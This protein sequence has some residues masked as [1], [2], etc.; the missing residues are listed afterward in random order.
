[1]AHE[2][3]RPAPPYTPDRLVL[4]QPV[5]LGDQISGWFFAAPV[6][7]SVLIAHDVALTWVYLL[8]PVPLWLLA[9]L[10][11]LLHFERRTMIVDR[12]AGEIVVRERV[13]K[14][15]FIERTAHTIAFAEVHGVSTSRELRETKLRLVLRG[16]PGVDLW[17]GAERGTHVAA[18]RLAAYLGVP[19]M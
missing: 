4:R 18:D 7:R 10:G 19:R 11:G 16:K 6:S 9:G 12:E 3:D 8:I 5:T 14:G 2:P 1:M 13:L 17:K 15:A